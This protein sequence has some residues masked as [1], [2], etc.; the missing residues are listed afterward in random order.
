MQGYRLE[1]KKISLYFYFL[2]IY[3]KIWTRKGYRPF[4][5]TG[6]FA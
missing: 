4:K 3:S 2:S 1:S 5:K 6:T